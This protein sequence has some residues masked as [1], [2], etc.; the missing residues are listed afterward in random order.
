MGEKKGDRN[1]IASLIGPSIIV[2]PIHRSIYSRG[3]D[4]S[5]HLFSWYKFIGPFIIM[6]LIMDL[7]GLV[8][9]VDGREEGRPEPHRPTDLSI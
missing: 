5:V 9:F 3:T 1:P 6:V 2:V 8:A 7:V 4:L